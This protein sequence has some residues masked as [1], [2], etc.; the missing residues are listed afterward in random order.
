VGRPLWIYVEHHPAVE[1]VPLR[2]PLHSPHRLVEHAGYR[3]AGVHAEADE[4]VGS[5]GAE[6]EARRVV[7][8][9]LV[10][11]ASGNRVGVGM[12]RGAHPTM[13]S[14]D[15]ELA[16]LQLAL[17]TREARG[18]ARPPAAG[19]QPLDRR[20]RP[21]VTTGPIRSRPGARSATG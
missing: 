1:P 4:R 12:L 16:V 15:T 13:M 5:D 19:R 17:G 2:V 14:V 3:G 21:G 8:V 18:G 9:G 7:V 20:H 11:P 10:D 6:H